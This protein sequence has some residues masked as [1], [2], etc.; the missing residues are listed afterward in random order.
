M[1]DIDHLLA[2]LTLG[3][4]TMKGKFQ[5]LAVQN[6]IDEL[7][8]G[9]SQNQAL[10]DRPGREPDQVLNDVSRDVDPEIRGLIV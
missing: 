5:G 1:V 9:S 8:I 6:F 10:R 2:K 4:Y 7:M 3:I